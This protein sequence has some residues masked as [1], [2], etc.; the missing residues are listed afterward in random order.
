M[1]QINRIY[2]AHQWS[3]PMNRI[4][5]RMQFNNRMH[6]SNPMEQQ[7]FVE[8]SPS[9]PLTLHWLP[10]P[11]EQLEIQKHTYVY[12]L[13]SHKRHKSKATE[14]SNSQGYENI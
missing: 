6:E 5:G 1:N 3:E 11:C 13:I 12:Q 14:I 7:T 2:G 4:N 9:D 8:S 10:A